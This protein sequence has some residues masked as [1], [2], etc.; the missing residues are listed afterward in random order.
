MY[1]IHMNYLSY[2]YAV[3]VHNDERN[4]YIKGQNKVYKDQSE[5]YSQETIFKL[6]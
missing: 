3:E 5:Y 4:V 6:L 2:R 1:V